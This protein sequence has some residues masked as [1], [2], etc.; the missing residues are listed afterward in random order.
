MDQ[1]NKPFNRRRFMQSAG[2]ALAT[3]MLP[4]GLQKVLAAPAGSGTLGS[5][6]HVVIFSQ[7]NRSFDSYFGSLNGVSG[8]ADNHPLLQKRRQW[9]GQCVL[10]KERQH[11]PM[12]VSSQP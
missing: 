8:F 10:S 9:R 4:P 5:I 11:H 7:E 1:H 6:A 2:A 3:S 12:P